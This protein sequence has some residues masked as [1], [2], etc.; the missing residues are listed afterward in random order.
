[1][2]QF[3][4]NKLQLFSSSMTFDK[5]IALCFSKP[6]SAY[7]VFPSFLKV[8]SCA[9]GQ[10]SLSP[11]DNHQSVFSY[12]R[13]VYIFKNFISIMFVILWYNRYS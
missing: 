1:M 10:S 3:M 8:P 11:P 7:T 2:V 4:E 6:L 13:L 5:C 12:R 9:L